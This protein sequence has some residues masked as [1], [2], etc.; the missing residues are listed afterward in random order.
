[1]AHRLEDSSAFFTA[2]RIRAGEGLS[3]SAGVVPSMAIPPTSNEIIAKKR[4]MCVT[5]AT[6]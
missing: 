5:I 4:R 6:L 2:A 3:A 1:V